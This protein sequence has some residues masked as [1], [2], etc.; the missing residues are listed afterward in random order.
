MALAGFKLLNVEFANPHCVHPYMYMHNWNCIGYYGLECTC[1]YIYA[2]YL[3][4]VDSI[5]MYM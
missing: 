3:N 2:I 4:K 5:Y 1:A